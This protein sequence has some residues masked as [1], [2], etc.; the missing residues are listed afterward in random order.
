MFD[1]K[2]IKRIE[3]A[4]DSSHVLQHSFSVDQ[5]EEV[6][7]KGSK[8]NKEEQESSSSN[9]ID[10]LVAGELKVGDACVGTKRKVIR[11][12]LT[13]KPHLRS[14]DRARGPVLSSRTIG[15]GEFFGLE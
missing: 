4:K 3:R 12:G 5:R 8:K 1:H 10:V 13:S 2:L 7:V 9:G 11:G 14:R 6:E 15:G